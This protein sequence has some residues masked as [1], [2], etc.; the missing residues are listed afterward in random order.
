MISAPSLREGRTSGT[1]SV[2]EIACS[3]ASATSNPIIPC[4][5]SIVAASNP[6]WATTSAA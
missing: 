2:V 5:Q 1:A 4:W 6:W 3:M